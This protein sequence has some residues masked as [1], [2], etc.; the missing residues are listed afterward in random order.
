[1]GC[2]NTSAEAKLECLRNATVDSVINAQIS[3]GI[4]GGS[5]GVA[6]QY[7]PVADGYELDEGE[8]LM[9]ALANRTPQVPLL[10]GSNMNETSLFQCGNLKADM[11]A[12]DT[13]RAVSQI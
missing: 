1:M 11:N 8:T 4:E 10:I 12:E 3:L 9:M 6:L 13:N 7:Y 2:S 5:F